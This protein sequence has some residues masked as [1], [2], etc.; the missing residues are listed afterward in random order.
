[1]VLLRTVGASVSAE[2]VKEQA[3]PWPFSEQAAGAA[4]GLCGS[5]HHAHPPGAK[6]LGP[7][8]YSSTAAFRIPIV[9]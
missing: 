7:S 9:S 6:V 2:L 4:G 3:G 5:G 8:T 1:M